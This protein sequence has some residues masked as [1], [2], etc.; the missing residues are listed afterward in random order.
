MC[1]MRQSLIYFN[2]KFRI[3]RLLLFW[4]GV[5]TY[6]NEYSIWCVAGVHYFQTEIIQIVSVSHYEI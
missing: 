2:R 1:N 4:F 6:M 5:G 3:P